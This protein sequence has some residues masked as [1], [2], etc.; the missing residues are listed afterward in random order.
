MKIVEIFIPDDTT[1]TLI[2]RTMESLPAETG[3]SGWEK[4]G[5]K[6]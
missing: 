1:F 3:A 6:A 5:K 2:T 4:Q